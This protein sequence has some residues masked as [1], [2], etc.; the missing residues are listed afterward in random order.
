VSLL[1]LFAQ[2]AVLSVFIFFV[3]LLFFHLS[4]SDDGFFNSEAKTEYIELMRILND[5]QQS[6]NILQRINS[7]NDIELIND[8]LLIVKTKEEALKLNTQSI[9]PKISSLISLSGVLF[10]LITSISVAGFSALLKDDENINNATHQKINDLVDLTTGLIQDILYIA[11]LVFTVLST[12]I[13]ILYRNHKK[14]LKH[15]MILKTVL[16]KKLEPF[17]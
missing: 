4:D 17:D 3:V 11:F 8:L 7:I 16:E 1:S 13:L 6:Q 10:S 5:N 12:Y 14:D 9:S 15:L 2:L